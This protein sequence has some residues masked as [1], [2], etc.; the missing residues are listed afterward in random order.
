M[1][2]LLVYLFWADFT[3]KYGTFLVLV[4]ETSTNSEQKLLRVLKEMPHYVIFIFEVVIILEVFSP[5]KNS[6]ILGQFNQK[7]KLSMAWLGPSFLKI[8]IG[9]SKLII[10]LMIILELVL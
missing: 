3:K 5:I 6:L 10:A 1:E 7:G 4:R 8:I 2:I 9:W